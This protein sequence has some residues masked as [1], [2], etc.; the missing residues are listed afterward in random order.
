M[1]MSEQILEEQHM[2][3]TNQTTEWRLIMARNPELDEDGARELHAANV[4]DNNAI[5]AGTLFSG[6]NRPVFARKLKEE[7]EEELDQA[8][9]I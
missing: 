9:D 5:R 4:R 6:D 8:G 2:L 7:M 3:A 1:P